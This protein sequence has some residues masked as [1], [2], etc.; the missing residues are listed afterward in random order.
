[1][2]A[3]LGFYIGIVTAVAGNTTAGDAGMAHR[4]R[5]EGSGIFMAGF[6]G[7]R[8]RNVGARFAQC[9]GAV[10]AAGTSAGDAGVVHAGAA[11]EAGGALMA[12]FTRGTGGDMGA[13]FAQ[14]SSAVVAASTAG[15][16]AG[17]VHRCRFEG[18]RALMAS[19]A[20]R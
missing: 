5:F 1:M 13:W 12:G 3:R 7:S 8:G 11:L 14:R 18:S 2:G 10:M 20:G 19:L 16:D 6:A 17:M 15:G 4:C 9:S